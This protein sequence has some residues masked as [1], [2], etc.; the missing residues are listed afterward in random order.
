M[1]ISDGDHAALLASRA[2][3][4]PSVA[5]GHDLVFCGRVRLPPLPGAALQFQ[6]LSSAPLRA[7]RR[8]VAVHFLPAVSLDPALQ[9]ARPETLDAATLDAA[10]SNLAELATDPSDEVLCYFRDR[11]GKGVVDLLRAAGC[12]VIW[13]GAEASASDG[14]EAL[15]IGE[16]PFRRAF[17][18][19][20]AVIGS[21]GS[22]LL[23]ECVMAGKPVLALYRDK[24]S[25]QRLNATLIEQAGV[26]MGACLDHLDSKTV[27]RFIERCRRE[28]F[29]RIDLRSALPPVSVAVRRALVDLDEGSVQAAAFA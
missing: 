16:R 18:R 25:E 2:A 19:A 4:I 13:F 14:I 20:R 28:D 3:S 7:A 15:P 1:V 29:A 8:W 6:R 10:T 23:A 11:N 9:L 5:V 26:G 17:S 24:D 21:A 22:N 27:T 12:R